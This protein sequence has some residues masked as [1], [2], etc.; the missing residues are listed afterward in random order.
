MTITK[1]GLAVER[2]ERAKSHDAQSDSITNG[3]EQ[4]NNTNNSQQLELKPKLQLKSKPKPKPKPKS[5]IIKHSS[6]TS[7]S[8]P[9]TIAR[10]KKIEKGEPLKVHW[11]YK[12]IVHQVRPW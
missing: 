6:L 4:M 3:E 8:N 1:I 2:S 10:K 12:I 9:L 5:I 7:D 11:D